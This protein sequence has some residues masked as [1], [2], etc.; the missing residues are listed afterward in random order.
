MTGFDEPA[1]TFET[2]DELLA[3]PQLVRFADSDMFLRFSIT[4]R[5][6]MIMA[7]MT[8]GKFWAVGRCAEPPPR[9]WFPE[10]IPPERPE[11]ENYRIEPEVEAEPTFQDVI[12]AANE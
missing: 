4:G 3:D 2:K 10:W 11:K 12:G 6:K 1:T 5:R 7:E 8:D 9:G